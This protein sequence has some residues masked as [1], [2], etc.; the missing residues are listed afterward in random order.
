MDYLDTPLGKVR[1]PDDVADP[2]FSDGVTL[3][4]VRDGVDLYFTQAG[5]APD[6][7][8]GEV[9]AHIFMA[10]DQLYALPNALERV[11]D[12]IEAENNGTG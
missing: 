8:V 12:Q 10:L 2:R 5:D 11:L 4:W 1:L 6:G 9:V 3:K 7:S